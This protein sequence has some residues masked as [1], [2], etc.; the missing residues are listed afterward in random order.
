MAE[1]FYYDVGTLGGYA[2]M[3]DASMR[4]SGGRPTGGENAKNENDYLH[5][6]GGW[7]RS[8]PTTRGARATTRGAAG[9]G[10][11]RSVSS[12][13][14]PIRGWGGSGASAG[15]GSAGRG[16]SAAEA[17][18]TS[19]STSPARRGRSVSAPR[20]MGTSSKNDN[21]YNDGDGGRK[22]SPSRE[23]VDRAFHG[24][25]GGGGGRGNAGGLDASSTVARRDA[26]PSATPR[27][28]S[29]HVHSNNNQQRRQTPQQLHPLL[30]PVKLSALLRDHPASF[31]PTKLRISVVDRRMSVIDDVPAAYRPTQ[32][33]YMSHNCVS[34]LAPIAAQFRQLRLLSAGDNPVDDVPQLDALARGGEWRRLNTVLTRHELESRQVSNS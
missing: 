32:R 33:L 1:D 4:F 24:T 12:E 17:S 5:D 8:E 18:T 23:R 30:R 21:S 7:A 27:G 26:P 25:G 3:H 16:R 11:R 13:R 10:H 6:A 20:M 15:G 2:A 31:D 34:S 22:R 19:A 29:H 28:D 9:G 14:V